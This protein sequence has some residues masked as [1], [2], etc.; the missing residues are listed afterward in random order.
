MTRFSCMRR[1]F[2]LIVKEFLA[3]VKDP[4]SRFVVV[5]PPVIQFFVFG[6][7][8]TYDLKNVPYAVL[9]QAR[10]AETRALL[11]RFEAAEA[12]RRVRTLNTVDQIEPVINR[13]EARL[14]LHLDGEFAR[15]LRSGRSAPLQVIADG[16]KSN[17][18]L[19]ALGY[20]NRI[21]RAH[22]RR[23]LDRARSAGPGSRVRLDDRAWF[24]RNLRS[25]WFITSALGGI[26]CMVVVL[27]LTALS[28]ARERE[29][30]TFDQLLV[31]PFSSW[32]ILIGK[33]VPGM[34]F[35]LADALILSMAAVWWF[36]VP[37]RGS[38]GV[39]TL[40]L[41]VFTLAIVG[42]GL[43]I[44]SLSRTMQQALLG[45]FIFIMPAVI[46]SGFA[47]PLANMPVWL[48]E[49][50]RINPVRYVVTALR[51]LFLEGVELRALWPQMWPL[52][53]IACVTLPLAAAF[54]RS[55]RPCGPPAP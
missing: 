40:L 23:S 33:S 9:D 52:A 54:F 12:F 42:V 5:G 48:R 32:E 44:S 45:G 13:Q 20:V 17:V 37:F 50:T 47:T 39:L 3:I 41:S 14:V 24:N 18:A 26:I 46:L 27:V 34:V 21:V 30:G 22:N 36:G 6:Y 2:A 15:C 25:R 35:G 19:I 49:A 38:V 43:F 1:L 28:V 16:R 4:K 55:C 51:R 29:F 53:A 7:A 10:T 8:A 11:A 31:A